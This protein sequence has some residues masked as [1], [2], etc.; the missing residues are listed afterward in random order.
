MG[1]EIFPEKCELCPRRCGVNRSAGKIGHCRAGNVVEIFRYG[2]H[3]GEEP[4]VSGTKGSGTVFFSRCTLN[5]LYCQNFPWSQE[6]KGEQYDEARLAGVF[7]SLAAEGCHNWNLVSP[8]PWLPA[9]RQ[10]FAA[11]RKEGIVLPV[12][13]NT[14]GFE[15]VETLREYEAMADI[16]LTDLR[17]SRSE[18][19]KEGSNAAG[20]VEAA[21]AAL[22]EMWRQKGPVVTDDDGIARQGTICR[23]LILPGRAVEA[24]ENLRWLAENIGT[25]IAVSVMSQYVPAYNA[26][27][28][29]GWKTKI[30]LDDYEMVCDE[31]GRFGFDRGWIQE[32][33]GSPPAEL[34]GF[35]MKS[36]ADTRNME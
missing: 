2:P 19:A 11:L 34:I 24:V 16:Y 20:Y 12:V 18:S 35:Q 9:I 32:F 21:R 30:T 28:T 3:H 29:E 8:T 25:E 27:L 23:L 36:G 5:C 13:Y 14:S 15:N 31:A 4:P 17:Y 33:E 22:L 10:A 7:R 6:G 1:I 26:G